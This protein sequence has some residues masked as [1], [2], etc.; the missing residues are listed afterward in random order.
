ML[1]TYYSKA[2]FISS[3][4]WQSILQICCILKPLGFNANI[5]AAKKKKERK[6]KLEVVGT[7]RHLKVKQIRCGLFQRGRGEGSTCRTDSA[8]WWPSE[9]KGWRDGGGSG[10]WEYERGT[11]GLLLSGLKSLGAPALRTEPALV[12]RRTWLPSGHDCAPCVLRSREF[13]R[14]KCLLV[15]RDSARNN[16]EKPAAATFETEEAGGVCWHFEALKGCQ[17]SAA[18]PFFSGL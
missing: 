8:C 10:V 12:F 18:P 17:C 1:C 6:K 16:S 5:S 7:C 2:I 4:V 13:G 14:E 3:S 9:R 15:S 11:A